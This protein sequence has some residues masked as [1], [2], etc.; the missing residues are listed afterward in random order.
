MRYHI[1]TEGCQMNEA[2]SEKL[3]AGLAKLGWEAAETA[4]EADLAVVNT[5]VVRQK[6]ED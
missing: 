6:A 1:W 2:D 4:G 5:C 3:A